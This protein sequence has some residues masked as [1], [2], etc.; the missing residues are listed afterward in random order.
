M[1]TLMN[2]EYVLGNAYVVK[3]FIWSVC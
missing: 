3:F 2:N 1:Q